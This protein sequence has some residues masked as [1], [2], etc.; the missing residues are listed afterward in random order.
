M[1]ETAAERKARLERE[2]K[3]RTG[4]AKKSEGRKYIAVPDD[5]T[6]PRTDYK[7]KGPKGRSG[8]RRD[9]EAKPKY[10][11]GGEVR[12]KP[13]SIDDIIRL[14]LALVDAGL[15][16]EDEYAAGVWDPSTTNAMEQL[17]GEANTEAEDWRQTLAYRLDLAAQGLIKR[18]GA[19]GERAPLRVDVTNPTDIMATVRSMTPK[20][21]GRVLRDDEIAPLVAGYQNI[22]RL[23]QAQAYGMAETGGE[24]TAPPSL[25]GYLEQEI[26]NRYQNE[27]SGNQL[28]ANGMAFLDMLGQRA[29]QLN[30]DW[31]V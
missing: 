23:T 3:E 21:L 4:G 16:A 1:A 9:Y 18:K 24:I 26:K 10:R 5:Y 11:P 6:V 27:V 14:Q 31:G 2:A 8:R 25:D 7:G 13:K 20:M 19:K 22:E 17:L 15:L 28:G 30:E 29:P 12:Q